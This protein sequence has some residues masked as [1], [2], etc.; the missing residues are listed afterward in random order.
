LQ[1]LAVLDLS[2]NSIGNANA[3]R[4]LSME[5]LI[6][7]KLWNSRISSTGFQRL[8]S[9]SGSL[10]DNIGPAEAQLISILFDI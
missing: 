9:I 4:I 1:D 6:N 7:L 8:C 10:S 5:A 3:S 2:G